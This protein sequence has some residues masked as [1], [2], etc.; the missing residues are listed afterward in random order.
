MQSKLLNKPP[1]VKKAKIPEVFKSVDMAI[2]H[3]PHPILK[4][5]AMSSATSFRHNRYPLSKRLMASFQR[6][7]KRERDYT[8][9]ASIDER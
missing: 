3:V 8:Y 7:G 1:Q 5:E 2:A 6:L 9:A 4:S